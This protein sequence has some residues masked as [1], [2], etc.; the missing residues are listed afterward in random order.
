[1]INISKGFAFV[2]VVLFVTSMFANMVSAVDESNNAALESRDNQNIRADHPDLT[3]EASYNKKVMPFA[4]SYSPSQAGETIVVD[5]GDNL[6][7]YLFWPNTIEPDI[8]VQTNDS[9]IQ[10][11]VLTLSIYDVDEYCGSVCGGVC[12]VDTVYFNGHYLG[13]LTGANNQWSTTT[14]ILDPSWVNGEVGGSPGINHV[15]II[16]DTASHKCWAVE[17]DWVQLIIN[18]G[19]KGNARIVSLSTDKQAY[20]PGDTINAAID[21]TTNIDSQSVR[22]ETNLYDIYGVNVD[23]SSTTL[24][25]HKNIITNV[26]RQ[27]SIPANAPSGEYT[28]EA[29]IY[30][31]A[32]VQQDKKTVIVTVGADPDFYVTA[33]DIQ[34]SQVKTI[35]SGLEV[36]VD[37]SI[38]YENDNTPRD[39]D[40]KFYDEDI[41][42][43]SKTVVHSE[44][45]S[46]SAGVNTVSILWKPASREHRL[47]VV[48]DPGDKIKETNENNNEAC[49]SLEGPTIDDVK[50]KYKGYFLSGISVDNVYYVFTSGNVDHVKFDMNGNVKTDNNGADGWS[51]T[52]DL[53]SLPFASKLTIT[54][55]SDAGIP[56]EPFVIMPQLVDTPT[57][58]I[59]MITMGGPVTIWS[60]TN[61]AHDNILAYSE[62]IMIPQDPVDV[63]INIPSWIPIIGGKYK[64]KIGSKFGYEFKSDSS[65]KIF[66]G[67]GTEIKI[68][69]KGG[70]ISAILSAILKFLS[71]TPST[72]KLEGADLDVGGS[73]TIPIP[74][75]TWNLGIIKIGINF[76]PGLNG[77]L[78]FREDPSGGIIA[79]LGWRSSEGTLKTALEGSAKIEEGIGY[80]EGKIGGEPSLTFKVPSPYFKQ[81]AAEIYAKLKQTFFGW[82]KEWKIS[83]TWSYPP[84][85]SQTFK[86]LISSTS[87][88]WKPL[89]RDYATPNYA[90]FTGSKANL[91]MIGLKILALNA[92][93]AQESSIVENVFPYASP[94]IATNNSGNAI[95]LWTHDDINKPQA[96]GFEIYYSTW[97]GNSWSSPGAVTDNYLPEFEPSVMFDS[98]GNAIGVWTLFNNASITAN[99][100]VFS[101]LDDVELAYSVWDKNT[102]TWSAPKILTNNSMFEGLVSLSN[103]INGDVSA[104]WIVDKDNNISTTSD[105]DIYYSIWNGSDWSELKMVTNDVA[106]DVN[107]V[108]AYSQ[109]NAIS[110]WSQDTDGNITTRTDK[111]LYYAVWNGSEWSTP[112]YLT[113]DNIEDTTPKIM[114]DKFNNVTL[115]WIKRNETADRIYIFTYDNGWSSP[116]LVAESLTIYEMGLSFDSDN[117]AVVVWQGASPSGQDIY[118]TVC[119]NSNQ[120]WCGEKQLTNDTSAEWQLSTTIDSKNEIMIS[121]VKQNITIFNHTIIEGESDLCYLIHPIM[122]DLS[123]D[124]SDIIFSN[125]TAYPGDTITI[126]AT[127]HNI[128]DLQ[129]NSVEVKFSD[130]LSGPQIGTTQTIPSLPAGQNATVSVT[131]NIPGLQQSHDIYV[132]VD[133]DDKHPETNESNNVAFTSIVL[134]DLK[135]NESDVTFFY[136]QGSLRINATVHNYGVI[137]ASNVLVELFDEGANGTLINATT[138]AALSPNSNKTI[139]TVWNTQGVSTGLHNISVIIDRIDGI[140][141]QNETNNIANLSLMILPDLTVNANNVSFSET[142]EGNITIDVSIRNIGISKTENITTGFFD[143]DPF[144]NGTLISSAMI[145]SISADSDSITEI[146]WYATQGQHDI[147]VQI[148]PSNL[149]PELDKSNNLAFNPVIITPGADLM[150]N[151]SDIIFSDA[152]E[153]GQVTISAII[154]NVGFADVPYTTIEF[155]NGTPNVSA[156]N[157]Y[158]TNIPNSLGSEVVPLVSSKGYVIVNLSTKWIPEENTTYNIYAK[159][160]PK[161]NVHE[162]NE[163]N[164]MVFNR[165]PGALLTPVL[166]TTPDPPSHDFGTVPPGQTQI[167]SFLITNCGDP[168]ST[169]TWNVSADKPWFSVSPSSGN[170]TTVTVAIDTRPLADGKEK[171]GKIT[172]SSN[173]ANGGIKTGDISILVEKFKTETAPKTGYATF[174]TESGY[175]EKVEA[176]AEETLPEA[177]KPKDMEF[178]HGFFSFEINGTTKNVIVTIVLPSAVPADAEYWKYGPEPN[179]HT[180]HW[181]KFMYNGQTGA[182]INGKVVTLHF[183]DGQRG[184][185]DLTQNGKIIDQGGPGTS[186]P[187]IPVPEFNPT[188]LLAFIGILSVALATAVLKRRR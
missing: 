87:G 47:C 108:L 173:G 169:L 26:N 51:M 16:I 132:K 134:P 81:V 20:A 139:S 41:N 178:P 149:I 56:S 24:T 9:D 40:V 107:P 130:G 4:S 180:P 57:W 76:I 147:Y 120:L 119:D 138:I 53:G 146:R 52:Y 128:G 115:T 137:T 176:V 177:G 143:G 167:W 2:V 110:V 162:S 145:D 43:G 156:T 3:K 154:H 22:L 148:D 187:P 29:I 6:D 135:I 58:I 93:G 129:A 65:A 44:K 1:M 121:Y 172:V 125:E 92:L 96:Q 54:A 55:F 5:S 164:N 39:V 141:E 98:N 112:T 60:L 28:V 122:L 151:S 80:T 77:V 168:G 61:F 11:A 18:A 17:C 116:K 78:C 133:P 117:N 106:V 50:P 89:P 126:N 155:Y 186:S 14:F 152:N 70:E 73:I 86:T 185:D 153:T 157:P 46:M 104:T 182:E 82:A 68:A 166:C 160:D 100:S 15:K 88:E 67:G 59:G 179:D 161:D 32:S 64:L 188:G 124:S 99:T 170:E 35:P 75:A 85:G 123:L 38:H 7:K 144:K 165:Y 118:Y 8:P 48:V 140:R 101:V 114:F 30:D 175:F 83:Y 21:L 183:V 49:K 91:K 150:L 31:S 142:S 79:G 66:G 97:D 158:V 71:G 37:T 74:G 34:F 72:L 159:V 62:T 42:T 127:I 94:S 33:Q 23:G 84:R 109:N 69:G 103:D 90:K 163:L 63:H 45:A 10:S 27:L 36:S 136:E 113:N 131:W 174:E 184:D 111:E 12:E 25:L 102:K 171:T 105:R 181:Y 19:A 95:M 13:T